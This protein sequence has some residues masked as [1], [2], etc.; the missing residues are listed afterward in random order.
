MNDQTKDENWVELKEAIGGCSLC[1]H[2]NVCKQIETYAK[3]CF[4]AKY[5]FSCPLEVLDERT[6]KE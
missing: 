4:A 5:R 6:E 3:H 2:K 1:I